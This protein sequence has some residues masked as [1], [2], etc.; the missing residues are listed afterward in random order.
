MSGTGRRGQRSGQ[1]RRPA[2]SSASSPPTA[3]PALISHAGPARFGTRRNFPANP[4]RGAASRLFGPRSRT[5]VPF[6]CH[7]AWEL[8]KRCPSPPANMLPAPYLSCRPSLPSLGRPSLGGGLDRGIRTPAA[9]C[10]CIC[11]PRGPFPTK[12]PP[13]REHPARTSSC[14]PPVLGELGDARPVPS[15]MSSAAH[16]PPEQLG[17]S[18]GWVGSRPSDP[19]I[20]LCPARLYRGSCGPEP[21]SVLSVSI[22]RVP[23]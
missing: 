1:R 3:N 6:C 4:T 22:S 7:G 14:S 11:G 8:E 13:A 21:L 17:R 10:I 20:S 19:A 2:S 15:C 9:S 16:G 18:R 5:T 12:A 23:L